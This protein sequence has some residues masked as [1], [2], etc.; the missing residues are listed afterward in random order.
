MLL[1]THSNYVP[2]LV[3]FLRYSKE[4]KNGKEEYLYSAIYTTHSQSAQTWIT[5][6][7]A[8]YT[9]PAFPS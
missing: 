6:L 7:P 2:T 8:K 9:M 4:G 1:A 3:S 5:V